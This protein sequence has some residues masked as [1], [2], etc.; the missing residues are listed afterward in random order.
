MSIGDFVHIN[1]PRF[2]VAKKPQDNDWELR[3]VSVTN[4][5]SGEYQCQATSHPPTFISTNLSV[6]GELLDIKTLLLY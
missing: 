2:L 4:Y 3:V 5:D 1:D 6:V